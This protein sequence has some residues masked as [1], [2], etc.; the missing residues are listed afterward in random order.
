M[1]RRVPEGKF[2]SPSQQSKIQMAS[3]C[4]L[5]KTAIRNQYESDELTVKS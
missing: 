4:H 3:I 1:L 5:S 2:P